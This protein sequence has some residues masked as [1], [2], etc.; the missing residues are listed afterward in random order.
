MIPVPE[1][2]KV[3]DFCNYFRTCEENGTHC[4]S[5]GTYEFEGFEIHTH[6]AAYAK[7]NFELGIKYAN[8][9]KTKEEESK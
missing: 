8:E 2:M 4:F 7:A 3:C 6:I 1:E 5:E 9:A